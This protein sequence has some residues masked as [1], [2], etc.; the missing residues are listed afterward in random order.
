VTPDWGS[1]DLNHLDFSKIHALTG[2]VFVKGAQPGD[3]LEVEIL[4]MR[5][6]GWGWSGHIIGFGLLADD[7]PQ[8]FI[9]HWRLENERCL[10]TQMTGLAIPF[11]PHPGVVGVA[12]AEPGRLDTT[13]PR[14][15]GGNMDVRD[16]TIGATLWLPVWVEGA[17]FATGDCHAAQ[18]Q[19]E[20]CGMGIESPM[21]VTMRF[22][23]RKDLHIKEVQL[24]RPG[25]ASSLGD[26]GYHITTAHGP[27]L[28]I[29]AQNSVRYMIDWLVT[30]HDLTPSQAYVLC[31]VVG[32]LKI[33]EI[34][35]APNWIVSMHM[36]LAI[37]A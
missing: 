25:P 6:Q 2:S 33:S 19:G 13:P 16:M 1:A 4:D 7:F 20:V 29:N 12:P 5:H 34:V 27:D 18:G 8:H 9:H 14:A 36:P 35:D 26:R 15:N 28:M 30:W 31:S 11:E 37:F 3:A 32:D 23:V 17:L 24:Q 21:T 22:N 10:S